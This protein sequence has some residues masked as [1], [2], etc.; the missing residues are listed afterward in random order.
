MP[1]GIEVAS[2]H[3]L[4]GVGELHPTYDD[5][6]VGLA[7]HDKATGIWGRHYSIGRS[8]RGCVQLQ[9]TDRALARTSSFKN[10]PQ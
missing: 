9:D 1:P 3:V 5:K 10:L 6:A 2:R 4:I 7:Q 8:A